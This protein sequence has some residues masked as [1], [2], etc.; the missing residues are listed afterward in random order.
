MYLVGLDCI[1]EEQ[2]LEWSVQKD[3]GLEIYFKNL[4]EFTK[5][6]AQSVHLQVLA[7]MRVHILLHCECCDIQNI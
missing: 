6:D 3:S 5:T 4:I 1:I 7:I 2:K